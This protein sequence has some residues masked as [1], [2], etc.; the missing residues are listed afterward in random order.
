[1]ATKSFRGKAQVAGAVATIDVLLYPVQQSMKLTHQF[2]MEKIKDADGQ[3]AS[4]R[5]QNE[6]V[7]FDLEMK[8]LGDTLAH[9]KAG[10]A[11]LAPMATV[12]LSACDVAQYNGAWIYMPN[13]SITAKNDA[14][15]DMSWRLERYVDATQNTL[16]T[17]T[18]S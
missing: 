8:L 1:M 3:Y 15:G 17:T 7:D 11:F 2:E 13:A 9:A 16:M 10:A 4:A 18:P 14:T 12:T 6:M 5:S